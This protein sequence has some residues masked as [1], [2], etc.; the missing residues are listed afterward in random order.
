MKI[1]IRLFLEIVEPLFRAQVTSDPWSL[2]AEKRLKSKL[3]R[4][5]K[6]LSFLS[7]VSLSPAFKG[8]SLC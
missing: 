6:Y 4:W 1:T 5:C 8:A 2:S 3:W 7:D